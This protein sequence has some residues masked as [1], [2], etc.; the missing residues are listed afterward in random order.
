MLETLKERLGFRF[1]RVVADSGYESLENYRY[2]DQHK[3]EAYI[4][5]S[6]YEES[7]LQ[8]PPNQAIADNRSIE[9]RICIKSAK[10]SRQRDLS[11]LVRFMQRRATPI[12]Q[13]DVSRR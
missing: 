10:R 11:L 2:L 8:A 13:K 3:Q 7:A 5:P 12:T 4:K 1:R 6:N 9:Q